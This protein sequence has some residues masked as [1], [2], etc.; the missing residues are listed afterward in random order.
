MLLLTKEQRKAILDETGF[1]PTPLQDPIVYDDHQTIFVSG[2]IQSGKSEVSAAVTTTRYRLGKLFWFIGLDYEQC[3]KEFEYT[4]RNLRALGVVR[5]SHMPSRDQWRME[6]SP[7]IVIE[8][9]SSKYPEKIAREHVDGIVLCEAG[10]LSFDIYRR[11]KERLTTKDGWLFASG[12]LELLEGTDWY[13][14]KCK[15]LKM[16]DNPEG[17]S[18]A[19]PTWANTLAYPGGREDPKLLAIEAE[20]GTEYF[21]QRYGGEIPKPRGLVI[22]EF[23]EN[24]HVGHYPLDP[25]QPVYIGVDPGRFPSAYAVEFGQ[26]TGGE[27]RVFDEIYVQDKIADQVCQAVIQKPYAEKIVGGAIDI[28]AKQQHSRG[29][30]EYDIWQKETGLRLDTR[31]I[32][33]IE[34]GVNR[35]RSFFYRNPITEEIP[36]K[37]DHKCRGLI[38][39]LGGCKSPFEGRGAWKMEMDSRGNILSGRPSDKNCDACKALIYMVVSR[40][41]L[42]IPPKKREISYIKV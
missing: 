21:M 11:A 37:I 9:K 6:V 31:R 12:T 34:D 28:Q 41:G 8:T 1:R 3:E 15:A 20:F 36:L 4:D 18:Y 19:L 7:G 33:P 16:P 30:P 27:I 10:Q 39:E 22:P 24:L 40:Y 23:R 26:F 32:K 17:I 38:S 5:N 14:E 2:G 25:E 35:L 42:G 13:A 29:K